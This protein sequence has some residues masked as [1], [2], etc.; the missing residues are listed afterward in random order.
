MVFAKLFF[1][2]L[3]VAALMSSVSMATK[4]VMSRDYEYNGFIADK[5]MAQCLA[6]RKKLQEAIAAFRAKLKQLQFRLQAAIAPTEEPTAAINKM[7]GSYEVVIGR[8]RMYAPNT[9][10]QT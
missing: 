3:A 6:E 1:A 8:R 5:S 7:L 4:A 9:N 10:P 2:V